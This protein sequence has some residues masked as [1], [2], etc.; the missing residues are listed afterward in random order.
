M[1]MD[2]AAPVRLMDVPNPAQ[3]EADVE[4]LCDAFE[5]IRPAIIESTRPIHE[6]PKS[7]DEIDE[8]GNGAE[9]LQDFFPSL[10]G[11]LMGM[12]VEP[13]ADAHRM[14]LDKM[15]RRMRRALDMGEL[16]LAG[17]VDTADFKEFHDR[18]YGLYHQMK[19]WKEQPLP[20]VGPATA[21]LGA[22]PRGGRI[23]E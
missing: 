21:R 3:F 1:G 11:S 2:N 14:I 10:A 17:K 8:L 23:K 5:R 13:R 6:T 19:D 18:L 20:T 12:T 4:A 15:D 9:I 16:E 7:S 22:E